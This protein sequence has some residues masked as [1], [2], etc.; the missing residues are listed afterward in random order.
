MLILHTSQRG[1]RS[2]QWVFVLEAVYGFIPAINICS[3][4]KTDGL[5]KIAIDCLT[6]FA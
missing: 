5:K 1:S 4:N 2:Q 3:T 6:E